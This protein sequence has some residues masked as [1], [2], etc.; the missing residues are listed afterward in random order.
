[1]ADKSRTPWFSVIL[2]GLLAFLVSLAI[3]AVTVA[4]YAFALAIRAQ[5]PPDSNKIEG[6]AN[7]V[8]PFLGPLIL[9]LLVIIAARWVVRRAKS[10][11]LWHGLLVGLVAVL[12]TLAF[13][14]KPALYDLIGLFLPPVA[15][16][17]GGLWARRSFGK[18]RL[19]DADRS[20]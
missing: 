1:M 4:G 16:L 7:R 9:S 10:T 15:G 2:S 11:G 5:G 12:P 19:V 14:R 20:R 3:T 17:L 18:P 6:F 13:L 8:I